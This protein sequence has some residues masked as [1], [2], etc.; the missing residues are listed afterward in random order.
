MSNTYLLTPVCRLVMGDPFEPETTDADGKPLVVKSGANIGAPRVSYF[1]AV[2]IPKTDPTFGALWETV[3]AIGAAA[4]PREHT[5][6]SFAWKITDGDDQTPNKKGKRPCDREGFPGHWVLH[7][8]S[9]L[10][11]SV[12]T[13]GGAERIVDPS[14]VKVGDYVRVNFSAAGNKSSQ[15]PG[16]FLNPSMIELVGYGEAI[17]SGPQASA[18]FGAAPAALPP[19]ASSTPVAS[20]PPIAP[21]APAPVA[22]ATGPRGYTPAATAP[23][24]PAAGVQPA[25]DFLHRAPGMIPGTPAPAAPAPAPAAPARPAEVWRKDPA[26][27]SFPESALRAA[28]WTAEQI[29]A[30]PIDDVPF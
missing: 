1:I 17:V 28:G 24:V 2:A 6:P 14:R 13:L 5:L 30:A 23:A 22:P 12:W 26:G 21:P 20:A 8:S 27:N 9:G 10:A 7:M 11:P 19:G 3:R 4:F 25:H 18:I 15:N 16:I 29:A